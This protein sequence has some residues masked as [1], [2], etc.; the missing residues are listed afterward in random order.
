MT[1]TGHR[2]G[3]VIVRE[4]PF[5]RAERDARPDDGYRHELLDG[6]LLM[7]T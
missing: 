2:R 3:D 4:C 5:T 6:V 7:T 1:T